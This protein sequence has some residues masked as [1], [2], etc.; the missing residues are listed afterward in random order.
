MPFLGMRKDWKF[1]LLGKIG[2]V[3]EV[4]DLVVAVVKEGE[5][6]QALEKIVPERELGRT[7]TKLAGGTII[8]KEGTIKKWLGLVLVLQLDIYTHLRP[9]GDK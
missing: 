8:A 5:V 6:V 1:I 4:L 7:K 3:E 2:A 9:K